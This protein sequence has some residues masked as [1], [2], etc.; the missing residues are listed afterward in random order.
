MFAGVFSG[1]GISQQLG[2][3]LVWSVRWVVTPEAVDERL[4]SCCI[5]CLF[6]CHVPD[7]ATIPAW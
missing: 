7:W 6:S 2:V 5:C 1:S 4:K 3:A